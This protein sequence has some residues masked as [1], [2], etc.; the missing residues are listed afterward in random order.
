[1]LYKKDFYKLTKKLPEHFLRFVPVIFFSKLMQQ[2][3]NLMKQNVKY[4]YLHR[5]GQ[6]QHKLYTRMMF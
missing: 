5:E 4:M 2:N 1:V 3:F 6:P